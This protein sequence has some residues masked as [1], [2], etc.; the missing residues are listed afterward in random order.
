MHMRGY[1]FF[2]LKAFGFSLKGVGV[3]VFSLF[4]IF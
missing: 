1:V 3:M 2:F 4:D